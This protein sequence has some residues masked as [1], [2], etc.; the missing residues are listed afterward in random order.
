MYSFWNCVYGLHIFVGV[1]FLGLF[2]DLILTMPYTCL[3]L[4]M[5][6]CYLYFPRR[7]SGPEGH[8]RCS[9]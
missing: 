6:G 4:L 3:Y 1:N 8:Q 7:R 5:C 9:R 2:I